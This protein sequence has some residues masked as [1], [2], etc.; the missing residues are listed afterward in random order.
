[1]QKSGRRIFR[2]PVLGREPHLSKRR[3]LQERGAPKSGY[4]A[5]TAALPAEKLAAKQTIERHCGVR[6]RA[7]SATAGEARTGSR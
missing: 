2:E 6:S 4:P 7:G 3:P 1:M 5:S